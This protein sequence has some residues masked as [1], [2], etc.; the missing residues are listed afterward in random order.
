[1]SGEPVARPLARRH[2]IRK[3]FDENRRFSLQYAVRPRTHRPQRREHLHRLSGLRIRRD[4]AADRLRRQP[5]RRQRGDRP[6]GRRRRR[7]DGELRRQRHEAQGARYSARR[8][9][10]RHGQRLRRG[11]R[12]V[13]RPAR[14]GAPDRLRIGGAGGLRPRERPLLRQ[15]LLVRGLHDH[16][17]AHARRA[18]APHRQ[19]GLPRRGGQGVLLDAR[20]AARDR[21][22]RR[23]FRPAVAHG[24]D[25]QRR[26][27]R[28]LP[29]GAPLVD[30]GRAVRLPAAREEGHHHLDAGH[31]PLPARRQRARRIDI[32][33]TCNEP[34]DV[35]GQPGAEF[36]L[37]IECLPG[38]LRIQCETQR[39]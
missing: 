25:L 33:S 35:D 26:D 1:M 7:R 30:Q 9:S 3:R 37:H 5:L 32:H 39:D 17:A 14:G 38:A 27:G 8:D 31:G 28:R 6:D 23:A 20:H 21:G 4:A 11:A 34:T 24:A 29:P 36:P 12:H 16:L 10:G 13:G 19:A 22:R 15:R 2:P 18:Q